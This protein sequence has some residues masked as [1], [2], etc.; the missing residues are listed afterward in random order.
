M[1]FNDVYLVNDELQ[2]LTDAEVD[3]ALE[4]LDPLPPGYR[5][6]LTTLG[7]GE[8]CDFLCVWTPSQIRESL[9]E[10]RSYFSEHFPVEFAKYP[11]PDR[12]YSACVPIASTKDGDYIVVWPDAPY[13]L[14]GLPRQ[15]IE[16]YRL[17]LGFADLLNWELYIG[18]PRDY[19]FQP[20][21]RFFEPSRV[22]FVW[23]EL[24][25][26]K[27]L[28]L[29]RVT[30]ALTNELASEE[31]RRIDDEGIVIL[32][33]RAIHGR[34]QIV[35]DMNCGVSIQIHGASK[36][37]EKMTSIVAKLQQMGVQIRN[38]SR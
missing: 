34:I 31:L 20:P 23:Y 10:E 18:Q 3:E 27:Q 38:Q 29:A 36:R 24:D 15:D 21:F 12:D 7:R 32:F 28:T 8:Y 35:G 6:Y 26:T 4:F 25:G 19:V 11:Y 14:I 13:E 37:R 1:T 16:C 33:P 9:A 17:P 30:D 22:D 2:L 5:E